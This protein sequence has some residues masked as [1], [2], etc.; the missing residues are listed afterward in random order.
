[1]LIDFQSHDNATFRNKKHRTVIRLTQHHDA[2]QTNVSFRFSDVVHHCRYSTR[3][4][5]QLR[6]LQPETVGTSN[7]WKTKCDQVSE[8]QLCAEQNQSHKWTSEVSTCTQ[9]YATV[10]FIHLWCVFG[11]FTYE[12]GDIFLDIFIRILEAGEH[13]WEDLGL[14]HHLGQVHRVLGDLTECAEYLSL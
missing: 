5:D 13:C 2:R 3:V 14:N 10:R 1:M 8:A 9:L 11:D 12:S 7:T 6:Q 4:H